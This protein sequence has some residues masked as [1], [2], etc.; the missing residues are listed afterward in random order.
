LVE[1]VI[2]VFDNSIYQGG[3]DLTSSFWSKKE[4]KFKSITIVLNVNNIDKGS[5]LP[6]LMH[7]LTHAYQDYSLRRKGLSYLSVAQKRGTA[8]NRINQ[9]GSYEQIKQYVA[10]I[11]YHLDDF[12]RGSYIAQ[13]TGSVKSCDKVFDSISDV[14]DYI[15]STVVYEN[16]QTIFKLCDFLYSVDDGIT[17]SR[18][19]TYVE[20]LSNLEFLSYSKF[21]KWLKKKQ[22]SYTMKFNKVLPKIAYDNLNI[23]EYA[24]PSVNFLIG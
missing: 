22:L 18:V 8:K 23:V 9:I 17:Q 19:L 14:L 4:G 7:E 3:Y 21:I 20:Q 6:I 24:S 1:K 2:L 11:L 12:E 15:K 13:I 10:W 5:F 16:Y